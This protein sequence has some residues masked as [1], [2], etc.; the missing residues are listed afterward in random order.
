MYR[1]DII[2]AEMAAQRITEETLAEETGLSR[3][4]ISEVRNGKGN[5]TVSTLSIIA[6]K[7]QIPL[8]RLFEPNPKRKLAA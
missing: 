5:P 6:K 3:S 4:T 8:A 7:L 2:R 1:D